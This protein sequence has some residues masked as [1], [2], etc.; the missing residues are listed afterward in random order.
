MAPWMKEVYRHLF[1]GYKPEEIYI[2]E[3]IDKYNRCWT[4]NKDSETNNRKKIPLFDYLKG[5]RDEHK[6]R[7]D[8][9][10]S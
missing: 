3:W 6:R 5:E 7:L 8:V 9:F 10:I 4:F 2:C 1:A